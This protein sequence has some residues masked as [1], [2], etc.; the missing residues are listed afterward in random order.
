M[1]GSNLKA[2]AS[3]VFIGLSDSILKIKQVKKCYPLR[4]SICGLNLVFDKE[5]R[6]IPDSVTYGEHF[7]RPFMILWNGTGVS[8]IESLF[9]TLRQSTS[10]YS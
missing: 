6:E 10:T 9:L 8:V 7:L 5:K 2:S 4:C 3:I 1:L